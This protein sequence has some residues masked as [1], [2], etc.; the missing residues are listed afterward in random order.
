MNSFI[1]LRIFFIKIL[2]FFNSPQRDKSGNIKQFVQRK[3]NLLKIKIFIYLLS[4]NCDQTVRKIHYKRQD[5]KT[6]VVKLIPQKLTQP[7]Y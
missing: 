6:E 5:L 3:K 2:Y 7:S 1:Y 4:K